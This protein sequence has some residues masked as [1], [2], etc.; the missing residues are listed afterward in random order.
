LLGKKRG[1][2]PKDDGK[3]SEK[4][5][6]VIMP[7][8]KKIKVE[9]NCSFSLSSSYVK[10]KKGVHSGKIEPVGLLLK[11]S[12]DKYNVAFIT[13]E[14]DGRIHSTMNQGSFDVDFIF[15]AEELKLIEN[16]RKVSEVG[17]ILNDVV[18]LEMEGTSYHQGPTPATLP[19]DLVPELC[20]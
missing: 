3:H 6:S 9:Q 17:C 19:E 4:S 2:A 8:I 20:R 15:S 7:L 12:T 16:D 1:R 10:V 5:A 11:G 14:N 13:G 18:E